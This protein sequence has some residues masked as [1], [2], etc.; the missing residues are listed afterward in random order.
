MNVRLRLVLA[1]F[2]LSVVPLGAVTFYAYTNNVRAMRETAGRESQLLASEL[3]QRMQLVT[4]QLS[5]RVAQLAEITGTG[6]TPARA[7]PASGGASR[8]AGT[9]QAPASTAALSDVG[10]QDQVAD[11]LGDI[12]M[13][14]DNV[15]LHN[16]R[17]GPPGGRG[18]R[19]REGTPPG[20]T[21]GQ[22]ESTPPARAAG[23]APASSGAGNGQG[24]GSRRGNG[25]RSF[26]PARRASGRNGSTPATSGAEAAS[27]GSATGPI[28]IDMTPIRREIMQHYATR[29][30]WERMTPEERQHVVAQVNQQMFG[31]AMGIRLGTQEAQRKVVEAQRAAG[32]KARE[33]AA[34]ARQQLARA[35]PPPPPAPPSAS[36]PPGAAVA[37]ASQAVP[38]RTERRTAF[39]GNHLD[40][41]LERNGQVVHQVNAEINL[42][43]LLT[44]VFATTRRDRGEVPFAVGSDG[45]LYTPNDADRSRIESLGVAKASRE[46][47]TTVLPD[48]IV[49]TTPDPTGS[50]LTFGIARPVGGSLAELRRTTARN[51]G[52]GLGFIALALVGIVPLATRLTRNLL[53]LSDGVRR[54]ASGDYRA[55][56]P[57]RSHDEVGRLAEAF[58]QM[59]ADVERHQ[60]VAVEQER[61]KRE[62]ELGRQIQHDMLP[63]APL[64]HGLAEV[65]G[66]SVPAREV[67]GDFFNYFPIADGQVAL[68]VGDVSGKGVGAALLMA[69]V[70]ASLR[71]RLAL[72]QDLAAIASELDA[73]IEASTPV[74]VYATLFVAIFDPRGRTLRYVNAGHHPQFVVRAGGGLERMASSGLPIG[75]IAGR[76]YREA[77]VDLQAGDRLFFYTDG[78]VEAEGPGDDMFGSERLEAV[79]NA[80]GPGDDLL[81]AVERAVA[82]FRAGH[83]LFDDLTMMAVSIG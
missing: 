62:L 53:A 55:R 33:V 18:R 49:V 40:V 61:L 4:A 26:G 63:Q 83:E 27:N 75:L 3:T 69:N 17:F 64:K 73:E 29:E 30:E 65:K 66:V 77:R 19:G 28:T 5:E 22:A 36:A 42:Q 52:F 31:V 80:C 58:N 45:H 79:L 47:G 9:A 82:D 70:Q 37:T 78:C 44:A 23:G 25:G 41:T 10:T 2:L 11:A 14:L 72:G 35:A 74:P 1:F 8:T 60:R 7:T 54:I 59:A 51:V 76:G 81:A 6:S 12:A 48:W 68:L 24:T 46:P 13:L 16:M 57:V 20:T 21:N 71:T 67:G 32:D 43:N 56:V 15:E 50:G 39:S 34:A 38:A